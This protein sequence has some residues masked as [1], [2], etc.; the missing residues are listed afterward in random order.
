MKNSEDK[1]IEKL[2][3]NLMAETTIESPSLDFTAKVMSGVFAVEKNKAFI[4]KPAISKRA[5][6]IILG[7]IVALFTF[8]LFKTQPASDVSNFN[9][10]F[11]NSEKMLNVLSGFQFSTLTANILFAASVMVFIQVFLLKTY[12]NK[13]L[14]K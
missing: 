14:H 1:K 7:A 3:E 12:L 11:L 6:F 9:L 2:V 8:L 4:Y 10:A 13:R 5:W